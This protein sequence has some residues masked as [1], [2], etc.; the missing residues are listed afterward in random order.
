MNIDE[1]NLDLPPWGCWHPEKGF[2]KYVNGFV[3]YPT[4]ELAQRCIDVNS[5]NKL[6]YVGYTPRSFVE[7]AL[8]G[9][10]K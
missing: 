2:A 1:K 4:K 8:K 6:S 3:A 10:V 7:A 9:E 5:V